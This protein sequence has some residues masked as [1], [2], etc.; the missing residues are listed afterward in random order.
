MVRNFLENSSCSLL[1]HQLDRVC[2]NHAQYRKLR[3]FEECIERFH[4]NCLEMY[5]IFFNN[6]ADSG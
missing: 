1:L 5:E 6:G 4:A 2:Q 3:I